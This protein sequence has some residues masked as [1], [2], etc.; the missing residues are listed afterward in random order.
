MDHVSIKAIRLL[1]VL[2]CWFGPGSLMDRC[3]ICGGSCFHA[4]KWN[5]GIVWGAGSVMDGCWNA[6]APVLD[7]VFQFKSMQY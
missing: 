2:V 5:I 3:C 7:S 4:N 6:V 1:A